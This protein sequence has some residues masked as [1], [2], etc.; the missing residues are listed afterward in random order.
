VEKLTPHSS[1]LYR[2]FYRRVKASNL[3]S[4]I[5][6]EQIPLLSQPTLVSGFGVTYARDRRD[7]PA[8]AKHGTFNTID[9]SDAI[10]P[11]GSSANFFRGF[12]QNSSFYSFGRAFVFA[13]SVRFG[14]EV[15]YGN[16]IEGN[17]SFTPGQCSEPPPDITPSVIPLPERFF[18]GGGTSLRGFGLNQAGPRDP[19]TG[20]PIGGLAILVFNQELRFPMRLP[21]IGN[22]IG[23]TLF[24][25]GGNVYTDVNHISFGWKAP[26]ITDLNYFS[27]TVGFGLR[28]PTPIGPVRVDFGYQLNPAAYQAT[29]IPPGGTVGQLETLHLPHFGFFFNIGPIF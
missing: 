26:S 14:A 21:I 24:Y 18:A 4:T 8:D 11:I 23:G 27:H 13:R 2:Y 28:Y 12:F 1:L 19:C 16:T 25:D 6:E 29:V 9:V 10:E 17:S 22:R 3:V 15:P 7:D 20:F 5:N